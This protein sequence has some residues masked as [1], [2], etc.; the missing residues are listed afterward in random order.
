MTADGVTAPWP[1]ER[2]AADGGRVLYVSCG[3]VFLW[4]PA[5]RAV[6]QAE[7]AASL[8]PQCSMPGHYLPFDVYD[9]ALAG[10]RTALAVG[11]GGMS[12]GWEIF[13]EPLGDPAELREV[14]RGVGYAECT[15]G[16]QGLGDLAGQGSLLVF[17]RWTELTQHGDCSPIVSQTIYRLDPL[18]CPCAQV[19]TSPGPLLPVDVDGG[20]VVAV[21]T[22]TTEVLDPTGVPLLALSVHARSAQLS[23]SDLVVAVRGQLRDYDART[24]ALVHAWPLPDVPTGA[25]CGSPHPEGCPSI[26]LEL[27]DAARGLAAY[28]FDGELHVVRLD[29][30]TDQTIAKATTARFMDAGLVYPSGNELHLVPFSQLG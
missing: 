28:V 12:Q 18:G 1:I 19:A 29:N 20:R 25:P 15:V 27:E 17:S 30:G 7:P 10:D 6:R 23:G 21:G 5:T 24:G 16:D 22:N 8:T 11:S 3:H 26:R 13:Q 14:A 2:V 4:T 9:V